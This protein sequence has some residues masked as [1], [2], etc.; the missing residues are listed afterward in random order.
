MRPILWIE[1]G[2]FYTARSANAR[3]SLELFTHKLKKFEKKKKTVLKYVM[4]K[5][6][7]A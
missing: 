7:E 6:E 5:K 3:I 1:K 2:L 4:K